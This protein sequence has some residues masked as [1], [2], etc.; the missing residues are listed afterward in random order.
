MDWNH[1]EVARLAYDLWIRRGWVHGDHHADW[2]AAEQ[3]AKFLGKYE[4]I[5]ELDLNGPGAR[6]PD[7]ESRC[8]LCESALG[9][10]RALAPIW[11]GNEH[12][13]PYR[14]GSLCAGCQG[15]CRAPLAQDFDACWQALGIAAHAADPSQVI[16]ERGQPAPGALKA[17]AQSL[18]LL[19]PSNE[20]DYLTDLV[21]WL[22]NPDSDQDAGLLDDVRA[23]AYW[24]DQPRDRAWAALARRRSPSA[25][26]PYLVGFLGRDG[27]V[28]E[29]PLPLCNRDDEL[30]SG[31][32]TP[33]R[34]FATGLAAGLGRV[35]ALPLTPPKKPVKSRA[36]GSNPSLRGAS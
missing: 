11:P 30:E 19:V 2:V 32:A 18:L 9:S 23:L 10:Q 14:V 17:L 7:L 27:L 6:I 8:R 22:A 25:E 20:L 33:F 34:S 5:V 16:A 15:E 21:E 29:L 3:E 26:V 28:L 12:A 36:R 35:R 24:S 31:L 1:D 13:P 4:L